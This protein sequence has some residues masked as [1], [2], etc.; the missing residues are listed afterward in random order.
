M[1]IK[2]ARKLPFF[3]YVN[4]IY[5]Q[6]T[7]STEQIRVCVRTVMINTPELPMNGEARNYAHVASKCGCISTHPGLPDQTMKRKASDASKVS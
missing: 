2:Y 1:R 3:Y 4:V 6:L 5:A 7:G